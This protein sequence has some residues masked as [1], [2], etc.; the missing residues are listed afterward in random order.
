[1]LEEF[2]HSSYQIK[3]YD[4]GEIVHLQNEVSESLDII[5]EG[6]LS[7]QK[8]GQEGNILKVV[9]F[10]GGDM[11][12][13]NLL[14]ASSNFYPMTIVADRKTV[15][16][17]IPKELILELSAKNIQFMDALLTVVADKAL[18]LTNTIDGIALKTIRERI[19]DFLQYESHIQKSNVIK[20]T[21]SKKDLAQRMGIQRSSLSRELN[22]MRK[23][24]LVE[25]DSKTITLKD[26]L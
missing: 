10:T 26:Q 15:V 1:M 2:K 6:E 22:K 25:Y 3:T 13:A 17:H 8:I 23:D 20:L 16:L 14:F 12:G 9:V 18:V 24:G 7:V 11:L 21:M 19:N 5:L 4:K